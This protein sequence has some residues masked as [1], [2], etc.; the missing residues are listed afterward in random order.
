PDWQDGRQVLMTLVHSSS[1]LPRASSVHNWATGSGVPH[2]C[3][4]S[5]H[6]LTLASRSTSMVLSVESSPDV[7]ADDVCAPASSVVTMA[8]LSSS[9]QAA[10]NRATGRRKKREK[11]EVTVMV[12]S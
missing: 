9:P 11:V 2:E 10:A 4:I 3:K 8:A 7:A 5:R 6:E 1:F 12:G